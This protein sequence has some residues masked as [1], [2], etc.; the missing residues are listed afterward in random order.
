MHNGAQYHS[1]RCQTVPESN[2][3]QTVARTLQL[4]QLACK[5][6]WTYSSVA[7]SVGH[8]KS[9]LYSEPD[10]WLEVLQQG[11]GNSDQEIREEKGILQ[12]KAFR[13]SSFFFF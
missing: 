5:I 9:L 8:L 11:V 4:R 13:S 10:Q 2:I 6:L 1:L 12:D 7:L 3:L